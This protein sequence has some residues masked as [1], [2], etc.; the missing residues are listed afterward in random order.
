MHFFQVC[1]VPVRL[2]FESL[3]A[4]IRRT[5]TIRSVLEFPNPPPDPV[6]V[7]RAVSDIGFSY[8]L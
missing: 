6:P 3:W 1:F 8:G 2:A 7:A 5:Q 4:C